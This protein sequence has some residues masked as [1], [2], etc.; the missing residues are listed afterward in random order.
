MKKAMK[1]AISVIV[2]AIVLA[3]SSYLVYS[4]HHIQKKYQRSFYNNSV[5]YTIDPFSNASGVMFTVNFTLNHYSGG[6]IQFIPTVI[7]NSSY[8]PNTHSENSTIFNLSKNST[9]GV[10]FFPRVYI[11]PEGSTPGA[12][13][14]AYIL[15]GSSYGAAGPCLLWDN[16]GF[17]GASSIPY[18]LDRGTYNVSCELTFKSIEPSQQLLNVTSAHSVVNL[19]SFEVLSSVNIDGG[20]SVSNLT[21]SVR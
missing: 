13:K 12:G 15:Y 5:N 6:S 18:H 7:L 4:N 14:Y 8:S 21:E 3:A 19:V 2:V 17:W 1:I 16:N 11:Y 9:Y 20:F 10:T